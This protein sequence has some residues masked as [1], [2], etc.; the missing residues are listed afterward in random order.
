MARDR[1][2]ES[3]RHQDIDPALVE[4]GA[5]AA[6]ES[7]LLGCG[8]C[9]TGSYELHS[10][11]SPCLHLDGPCADYTC[12][13]T[14]RDRREVV[15][16][17]VIDAVVP[18]IRAQVAAELTVTPAPVAEEIAQAIER[19]HADAMAQ[20]RMERSTYWEGSTDAYDT[21]ARIARRVGGAS[22]SE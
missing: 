19:K 11:G 14:F 7:G 13:A 2:T 5:R 22:C 18:L 20:Y 6:D 3:S 10:D 15:A 16:A 17:A 9:V 8:C 21:A 12:D 4:A 1:V